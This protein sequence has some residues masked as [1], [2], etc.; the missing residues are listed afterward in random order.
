[1][2]VECINNKPNNLLIPVLGLY[3]K[4]RVV[5]ATIRYPF[6]KI[7]TPQWDFRYMSSRFRRIYSSDE[8][9]D[10]EK[11]QQ[12]SKKK[13][14]DTIQEKIKR[15]SQLEIKKLPRRSDIR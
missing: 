11:M 7:R 9:S 12:E 3:G 10:I 15:K 5:E 1:M 4:Y 13:V 14:R 6:L 8:I 2:L